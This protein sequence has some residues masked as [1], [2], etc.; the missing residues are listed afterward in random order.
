MKITCVEPLS[1]YRLRLDFDNG[2]QG[3]VD[4]SDL[5]G[6]GVFVAWHKPGVFDQARITDAGAVQWPGEIDLCPDALY[7]R[8][9]GGQPS[10]L[11]SSLRERHA[12]A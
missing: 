1:G 4:L 5:A 10:D 8:L 12:H 2:V 11:F 3:E 9:T 6:R 7:L